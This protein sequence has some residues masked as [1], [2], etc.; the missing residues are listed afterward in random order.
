MG[1]PVTQFESPDFSIIKVDI[2]ALG[3]AD[4]DDHGAAKEPP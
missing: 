3:L 4:Q 2:V 1:Q